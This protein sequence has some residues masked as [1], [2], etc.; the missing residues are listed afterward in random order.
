MRFT[1]EQTD[2]KQA[3]AHA[4]TV[5]QKRTTTL[6]LSHVCLTATGGQLHLTATDLDAELVQTIPSNIEVEGT[7]TVNS[8]ILRNIASKLPG[9]SVIE[10]SLEKGVL[11][12]P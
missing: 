7:C 11:T 12:V 4:A 1:I 3:I 8:E 2:L 6:I 5:V 10:M 9:A